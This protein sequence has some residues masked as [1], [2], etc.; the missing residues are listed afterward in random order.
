MFKGYDV[1]GIYGAEI[2][3]N[4]FFVLGKAL[5]RLG[6][7]LALGMDYR[8][9]NE[10]LAAALASGFGG[11]TVFLGRATTPCVAFCSRKLGASVTASHN[12][13][14]YSGMKPFRDKRCFYGEELAQL[15]TYYAQEENGS[16]V[17]G[18][19]LKPPLR[20]KKY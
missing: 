1:R 19:T 7:E 6:G 8:R 9:H 20:E 13:P 16:G 12:P 15:K 4:K 11:K 18:K 17:K 5:G 2:D 3:E 10:T 14:E